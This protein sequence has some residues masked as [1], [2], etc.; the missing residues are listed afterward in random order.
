MRLMRRLLACRAREGIAMMQRVLMRHRPLRHG[1][2]ALRSR[3]R[4]LGSIKH[5]LGSIIRRSRADQGAPGGGVFHSR[6]AGED[7]VE[8]LLLNGFDR[9][10][11][12]EKRAEDLLLSS[13]RPVHG[14]AASH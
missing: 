3:E 8:D 5:S 13:L 10:D 4:S 9:T 11:Q 6:Q 14:S 12:I 1:S 7:A 2:S